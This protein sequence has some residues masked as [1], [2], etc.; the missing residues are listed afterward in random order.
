MVNGGLSD[1]IDSVIEGGTFRKWLQEAC[2]DE[3][4]EPCRRFDAYIPTQ[5][6]YSDLGRGRCI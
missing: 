5:I 6:I 1:L 3:L 2:S 4:G